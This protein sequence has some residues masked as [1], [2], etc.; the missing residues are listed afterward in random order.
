MSVLI[1]PTSSQPQ[2]TAHRAAVLEGDRVRGQAPRE[3]RDDRE[4]DGEVAEPSHRAEE[5]L[6]VAQLVEDLFVLRG[7]VAG[8]LDQ[9]SCALPGVACRSQAGITRTLALTCQPGGQRTRIAPVLALRGAEGRGRGGRDRHGRRR[10]HRHAGPAHGKA[11]PRG[12][13]LR[14]DGGRAS[15]RRLQLPPRA[16]HGDGPDPGLRD[17]ELGARLRRLRDEAGSRDAAPDPVARGDRTRPL[18]RPLARRL[19]RA[20]VAAAGAEGADGSGRGARLHA[21]DRL[22]ARVLPPARDLRGGMGAALRGPDAVRPV[23]PRL[24]HPRDDL[25]RGPHPPD[26][27]RDARR[28]HQGRDLQGRGVAGPARDQLPLRGR[29]DDGRQPRDL[30]ERREG[31]REPQRL[32]DHVHGEAVR[33]VDRELVPHPRVAL[34]RRRA[35]VPRRP[36][37]LR[38][39]PR[40]DDR[41]LQGARDL[42]R[43]DDQLVQALRGRELGADHARLGAGQPHVRLP[44][45]RPRCRAARRDAHPGRR[46]QPVPRVRGDDRC[47]AARHRERARAPAGP[48]GERVRVRRGAVPLV[49]ARGDPRARA[50]DDGAS[51]RSATRSSTTT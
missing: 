7:V 2:V 6:R 17:R 38:P 40:R 31:D 42:P 11:A 48:R 39:L 26:P 45:R 44:A 27:Q 30:Q 16:R 14:G 9:C 32:L 37:A 13:L 47:R 41:V 20:A 25:R 12:V 19:A 22:G 1:R 10:V 8:R 3:D 43:A 29:A 35:C 18:R 5:L 33:V 36:G 34:P 23:H 51:A 4:A 28:R 21:D 24:P 15:G 50:R 49:A 46:R